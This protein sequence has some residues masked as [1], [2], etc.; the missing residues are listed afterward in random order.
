MNAPYKSGT[1][2]EELARVRAL[3]RMVETVFDSEVGEVDDDLHAG[4]SIC[5]EE[6]LAILKGIEDW[7]PNAAGT[8]DQV[9]AAR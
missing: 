1:L 7:L 6:A 9:R 4:A 5:L 8:N 2:E 3:L